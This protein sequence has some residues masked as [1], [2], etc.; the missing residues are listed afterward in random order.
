MNLRRLSRSAKNNGEKLPLFARL[1]LFFFDR[2]RISLGLWLIILTLGLASYTTLL[3]REGFPDVSIPYSFINGSYLVND[4]AKVDQDIGKPVSEVIQK[5]DNVEFVDSQSGANFFTITIQYTED[6][7]SAAGNAAVE[8]AVR[9]SGVLPAEAMAEFKPLSPEVNDRGDDMLIAFYSDDGSASTEELASRGRQAAEFLDRASPSD[10]I[11]LSELIDPYAKGVDP[12]TGQVET[13]QKTF[14]RF[15]FRENGQ[16]KFFASVLIG[17]QGTKGFDV[18]KLDDE[19]NA[20]VSKLNDSPDFEGF[21]A[22]VAYSLAPSIEMQV[23][24]LQRSLLEGLA[25]VLAVSALLIALRAALITV[26]SMIMVI[27]A[28]LALLLA[29]GYSLNT[30]TLFSLILCLS[31]IVDDTIIMVESIDAQRRRSKRAREAVEQASKKISRVMVAATLTAM[32]G[33]VPLVFVSGIL[34]SFI[35]AIPVTIIA[36]L[37]I[38]LLVALTFI[39]VLSRYLLLRPHQL[40]PTQVK[41]SVSH[42][43]EAYIA[44]TI[45][46]PLLW[47]RHSR[48]RQF[49]LGSAAVIVGFIFIGAGLFMFQKVPFNVFA[50]SRDSDALGGNLVFDS[51]QDIVEVQET[52]DRAN[53]IIARET[54]TNFSRASYYNTGTIQG[55]QIVVD[56]T[57]YKDR[58]ITAPQL[59]DQLEKAFETFN[60]AKAQ[61]NL[62]DVGPPA[63]AFMVRVETDNREMAMAL[64]GDLRSFLENVELK[65]L[66]GSTARLKSVTVASPD[67]L[68]RRDGKAYISVTAAEFTGSDISA[69]VALTEDAIEKRFNKEKLAEYGLKPGVIKP[70]LGIEGD[71]QN[72]FNTMVFAFPILLVAIY[73]LLVVQFR[74]LLQPALIFMAIPFSLFGIT[75]GLW[76]TGN[77]FSFFTMLGFFALL[78]LSIKNTILLT[79]YANR[80]HRDGH[81]VIDSVAISL[82]ERFRPLIATSFTAIVSL[83]PLYLANP[84]WEGLTVTL[85]FGLLSSTFLVI[86]AFPYFYLGAEYMRLR[87]RRRTFLLW[88]ILGI[89]VSG[90]LVLA[91]QTALIPLGL[92]AVSLGMPAYRKI[93]STG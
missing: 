87:I 47:L 39:P 66:D 73:I 85:I 48:R 76:L 11:G 37:L 46:R 15:G 90:L 57:S 6:V 32:I 54:G 84:F 30:I 78:G 53:E 86:I 93:R 60:G 13:S 70:D 67:L 40:G 82:Q 5:V 16:T 35:R 38:S 33:F 79:D 51:G 29:I 49:G 45:S 24:D 4:P 26:M 58:D 71:F 42:H 61:F 20:A 1:T 28:T 63:A 74:S 9:Q 8:K 27:M 31:L 65:R 25:A 72:S 55:A 56:L 80:A 19:V 89:A 41:E 44:K 88:L 10:S 52:A 14:D 34:G 59:T 12:S 83:V 92:L 22:K 18:L 43:L 81:S 50:P 2:P 36:A 7:S 23:N 77:D 62:I 21:S 3:R 91:G 75:G 68:T 64:A 17:V 69:L